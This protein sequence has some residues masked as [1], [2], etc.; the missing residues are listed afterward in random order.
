MLTDKEQRFLNLLAD[1]LFNDSTYDEFRGPKSWRTKLEQQIHVEFH[2]H[3]LAD[4]V[5]V[6]RKLM[7]KIEAMNDEEILALIAKLRQ[8]LPPPRTSSRP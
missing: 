8:Q 2:R 7:R 6:E 4:E 1:S 3:Q 5:I